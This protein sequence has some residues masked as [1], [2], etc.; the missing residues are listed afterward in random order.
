MNP[1]PSHN[2]HSYGPIVPPGIQP[3][4]PQRVHDG[5]A[6]HAE[7]DAEQ[8]VAT[9][10]PKFVSFELLTVPPVCTIRRRPAEREC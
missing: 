4:P 10:S 9:E 8:P 1:L 2:E 5:P 7:G 3:F 6:S